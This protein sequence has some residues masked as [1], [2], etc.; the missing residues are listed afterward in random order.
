MVKLSDI[1]PVIVENVTIPAGRRALDEATVAELIASI[2]R[3]GLLTPITVR[4]RADDELT[5]IAGRHRLEAVRR[6]GWESIPAVYLYG[7]DTDA[8]LWEIAEN[9]HRAELTAL[10]QAEHIAEWVRLTEERKGAQL[11]PPGGRQP[12]E[13]G[14]K[15]AVRELG[16]ER[17]EA[18]RAV[19]IDAIA[20]EA[21]EAAI[22]AGLANNQ[23]A[24]LD[25]AK[26]PAAEQTAKVEDLARHRE[27]RRAGR[28]Q[29]SPPADD[30]TAQAV[31]MLLEHIP[32]D[33]MPVLAS[34]LER[35][36]TAAVV[37]ALRRRQH[38]VA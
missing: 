19:K 2:Q 12:H 26:A 5:L 10:E 15:A 6:L 25:V 22:A 28:T 20:P 38:G 32:A 34:L 23:S 31:A 4:S 30:P 1:E 35:T 7:D 17:T 8:R 27:K 9:L 16:I 11:A 14:I 21:K 29:V 37:E 3:L 13:K 18:Q 36:T 24:L 33:R